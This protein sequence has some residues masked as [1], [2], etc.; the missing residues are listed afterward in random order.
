M[1]LEEQ[2]LKLDNEKK[3]ILKKIDERN[4]EKEIK[5]SGCN[6]YHKI[7]AL[8]AIQTHWHVP[9]E[10]C[11]G[12]NYYKEG[13]LQFI[14]PD[15]NIINRL[16]FNDYDIPWNQRDNPKIS[17]ELQFKLKYSKLFRKIEDNYDEKIQG[18]WKNNYYVDKNRE[19]FGLSKK[20]N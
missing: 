14:C 11:S 2:L 17:P 6:N 8:D 20:N 1:G 13:E 15:T 10:G 7:S 19:I 9:P 18:E 3:E 4:K 12:G 5:C 16:L